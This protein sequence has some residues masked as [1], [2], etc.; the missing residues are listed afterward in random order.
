MEPQLEPRV[1]ATFQR[2]LAALAHD[3]VPFVIGGA[4]ALNHY[5]GLWRDTKDLDVFCRPEDAASCLDTLSRAGFRSY[6]VEIHWLGKA[7]DDGTLVDVI[8]GGGNWATFV[9]DHWFQ[10][11]EHGRIADTD[12]PIAPVSDMILSKAWVAGRER[13]DGADI[14]HMILAR[15]SRIDWQ[16]LVARF[17][18]AWELLLQYLVLYRY[19]YPAERDRVPASLIH[20][21]AARVGT[22]AELGDGLSFRG[23]LVDRYAYLYDLRFHGR[24]DPR[25]TIA[26]RAG[27]DPG[28]VIRRRVLDTDVFDRGLPYR[29][30]MTEREED[31]LT[32]DEDAAKIR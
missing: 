31:A 4:F 1:R 21:L 15:G 25:E 5:T 23:P 24:P 22:D 18:D 6:V 9:D 26:L 16:D 17:G 29:N 10:H 27:H 7:R 2:A 19:V 28:M 3:Q 11:A 20:E 14:T 13:F 12:V 30:A 32:D 8:W